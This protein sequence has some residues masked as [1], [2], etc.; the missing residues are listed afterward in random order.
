[1]IASPLLPCSGVLPVVADQ[2]ME[3]GGFMPYLGQN[4]DN[5]TPPPP[6]K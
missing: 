4:P 6:N 3:S 2:Q 5:N 1:M